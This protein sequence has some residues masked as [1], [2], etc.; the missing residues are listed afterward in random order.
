[1]CTPLSQT[2]IRSKLH[3]S[4]LLGSCL[5]DKAIPVRVCVCVNFKHPRA[6]TR[7]NTEVVVQVSTV[8]GWSGDIKVKKKVKVFLFS[9]ASASTS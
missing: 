3:T 9:Q 4:D 1:M 5:R 7:E 2:D 6:L 8:T